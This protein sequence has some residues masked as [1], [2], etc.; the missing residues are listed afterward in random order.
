MMPPEMTQKLNAVV[1]HGRRVTFQTGLVR[2]CAVLLTA[3]L[4]VMA[5]DWI[6]AFRQ[7]PWRWVMTLSALACGLAALVLGCLIPMLRPRSL[8]DVAHEVDRTHPDLEERCQTLAEFS[9]PPTNR[10]SAARR[11]C[12]EKSPSKLRP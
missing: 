7:V 5:I 3:M 11:P 4:V 8:D 2:A 9:I 12:L 1:R 10:K 6:A